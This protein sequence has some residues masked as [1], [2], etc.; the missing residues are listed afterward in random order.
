MLQTATITQY[1]RI[2]TRQELPIGAPPAAVGT[3][4]RRNRERG[5]NQ[6]TM[7]GEGWVRGAVG[8]DVIYNVALCG[9]VRGEQ[10]NQ[11][12]WLVE[13]SRRFV[14]AGWH[15]FG[16]ASVSSLLSRRLRVMGVVGSASGEY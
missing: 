11:A 15:G 16:K 10:C 3:T 14:R 6:N 13:H 4:R 1:L 7:M 9:C 8:S 5:E 2:E 12:C